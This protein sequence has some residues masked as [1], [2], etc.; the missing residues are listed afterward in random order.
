VGAAV[1]ATVLPIGKSAAQV[2]PQEIPL[3][4]LVTVPVPVPDVVTVNWCVSVGAK[5]NVATTV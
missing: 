3:G 4:L 2:V 1:R 5:L